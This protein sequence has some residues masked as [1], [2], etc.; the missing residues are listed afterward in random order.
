MAG[1]AGRPLDLSR[2]QPERLAEV[3]DRALRPVGREGGD[4]RRAIGT[5]ALVDPR[6]QPLADVA[7]EVEVDVRRLG[8]LLVQEAPEE[9]ARLDRIDVGEA[10]QV[11]DDRADARAPAR[12]PGGSSDRALSAPRTSTATS[13]ASSSRSR[14]SRKNPES[15]SPRDQPQLLLEPPLGLGPLRPAVVAL[16]EP[17]SAG[18]GQ[19]A[20][21]AAVLGAR[22]AVA[23]VGGQVEAEPRRRA[24][25]SRR[26]RRGG[27][28]SARPPAPG[29]SALPSRCRAARA[30]S[31]PGSRRA[32]RRP[33]RPGAGSGRDRG[34]GR[35]RSPRRARRAARASSASR[36]LRARSPRQS[37]TL[38]LDAEAIA[39]ERR[40]QRPAEPLG[41]ARFAAG[42]PPR[43]RSVAGAT[44]EADE[45]LGVALDVAHADERG[46]RQ[47]VASR[48]PEWA[49]V[50]SRQ[51]LR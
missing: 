48:V 33:A 11:T 42:D 13:R 21:G 40:E 32:G 23:E 41:A 39:A 35:R 18:L 7:R 4:Q 25:R 47:A 22:V 10:G 43:Q 49:M 46:Q 44:G 3:A 1:R 50:S 31:T 16:A 17:G 5:V 45:P 28:G 8:D 29:R 20:V 12:G 26:P 34:R 15:F 37:G 24:A 9:Q 6:D 27:R 30:P 36:R 38:Q 51:R 2:R 14:W 19:L